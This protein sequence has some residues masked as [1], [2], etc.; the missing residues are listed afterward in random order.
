M[1][2]DLQTSCL[3]SSFHGLDEK[4]NELTS[5][6]YNFILQSLDSCKTGFQPQHL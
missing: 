2:V 5:D 3:A 6:G 1:K 4:A